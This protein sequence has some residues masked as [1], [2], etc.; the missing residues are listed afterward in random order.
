MQANNPSHTVYVAGMTANLLLSYL[1]QQGLAVSELREKLTRLAS[2]PR[3][4]ITTWWA[5]LEEIYQLQP[6]VGLG[7]AIGLSLIHISEPTRPY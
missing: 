3:M 5:L 2:L 4:P 1:D 6:I 7:L